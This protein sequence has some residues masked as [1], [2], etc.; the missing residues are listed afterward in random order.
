MQKCPMEKYSMEEWRHDA[1]LSKVG[2]VVRW[3]LLSCLMYRESR[4]RVT[5]Q[6]GIAIRGC[7]VA[8]GAARKP[9]PVWTAGR[10]AFC[11]DPYSPWRRDTNENTSSLSRHFLPKGIDPSPETQSY[12]NGFAMWPSTLPKN[13]QGFRAQLE[14]YDALLQAHKLTRGVAVQT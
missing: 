10:S 8:A 3:G 4:L 11:A 14:K 9:S 7:F 2:P 12:L 1:Q 13:A 5:G 6:R